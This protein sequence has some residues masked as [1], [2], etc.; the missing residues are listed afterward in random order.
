MLYSIY[1]YHIYIWYCGISIIHKY[2]DSM[3]LKGL[4]TNTI[5]KPD[6]VF[7]FAFKFSVSFHV[8]IDTN[9]GTSRSLIIH[10][11]KSK[12]INI[13]LRPWP[14]NSRFWF[15]M[16]KVPNLF[17]YLYTTSAWN[18]S[19]TQTRE[20]LAGTIVELNT[21]LIKMSLKLELDSLRWKLKIDNWNQPHSFNHQK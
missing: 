10:I 5:F 13:V 20:T 12:R 18:Q 15:L 14:N 3:L 17:S 11:T 6:N 8:Y 21:N 2:Y 1:I 4:H 16:I 7:W 9:W 19:P